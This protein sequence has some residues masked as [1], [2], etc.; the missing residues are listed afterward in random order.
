LTLNIWWLIF[1]TNFPYGQKP[2]DFPTLHIQKEFSMKPQN[3]FV[4]L[5]RAV[6]FL[7]LA[8]MITG[9][10]D[11]ETTPT[12]GGTT[13]T[14]ITDD[15]FPLVVGHKFVYTGYATAPGSGTTIPDPTSSYNTI[16]TVAS[17]AAPTPLGGTATALVDSTTGPFGPGGFVV[18]VARTLLIQ[19]ESNGDFLFI[20]TLGPFK[21]AFGIPVGTAASDTLFWVAVARPSH[22][23]GS[24][25]AQWTGYDSTFTGT[26]GTQVQLQI[27]GKIEAMETITDSAATPRET[28]RSRT[29][30]KITVGG[31]VV[32]DD[33]TTSQLWLAKD[34][35]PIQVRIVEDTEN[36]GHF[37]VLK[38]K[39]F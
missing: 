14:P 35:G 18:T 37:R 21:R 39:N 28:F 38:S 19:K 34:I 15:L 26:G 8:L 30:R 3:L 6:V 33:A 12:D 13:I 17:N 10:P 27:F 31:S 9:C 24:T 20:Q 36:I 22:G 11:D 16:W 32:Q 5:S 23:V 29:W 1:N 2:S 25:G 7:S 4:L